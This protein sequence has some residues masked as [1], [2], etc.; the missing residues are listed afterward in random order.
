MQCHQ[1]VLGQT[2]QSSKIRGAGHLPTVHST[3]VALPGMRTPS[4]RWNC[5]LLPACHLMVL[6]LHLLPQ[7]IN[8]ARLNPAHRLWTQPLSAPAWSCGEELAG[9]DTAGG[10]VARARPHRKEG[11]SKSRAQPPRKETAN[12]AETGHRELLLTER[13]LEKGSV[14][15]LPG[16]N[17]S[18][19]ETDRKLRN[20]LWQQRRKQD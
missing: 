1:L 4:D 10:L 12:R 14:F 11:D 3:G 2:V 19:S 16:G 15:S 7:N 8:P 18:L 5:S 17:A 20:Q 6:Q 9:F 13:L